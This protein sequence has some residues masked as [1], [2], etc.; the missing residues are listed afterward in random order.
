MQVVA[1]DVY[2][3]SVQV[4]SLC[5]PNYMRTATDSLTESIKGNLPS[6]S[7]TRYKI[8]IVC[9]EM[10]K[11]GTQIKPNLMTVQRAIRVT[12]TCNM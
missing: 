5:T 1:E 8:D 2:G 4:T 3:E 6:R 10:S 7:H 11:R 12:N 9:T